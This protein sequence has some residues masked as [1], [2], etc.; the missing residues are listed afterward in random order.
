MSDVSNVTATPIAPAH[1]AGVGK[2]QP[3][4]HVRAWRAQ[5]AFPLEAKLNV[6]GGNLWRPD[7]RPHQFYNEVL[8]QGP[9]T[10]G[11]CID[12]AGALAEPFTAKQ[13]QANL[14]WLYTANGAFLE[15]DGERFVSA[16][17]PVKTKPKAAAK[18]PAKK[19]PKEVKAA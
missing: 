2:A 4:G 13:T 11:E 12:K 16:P 6:I 19:Q 15:V 5:P 9:M 8:M 17:V 18:K 3:G 14:R 7:T 1:P 10:V